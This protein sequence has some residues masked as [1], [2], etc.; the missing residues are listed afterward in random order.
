MTY[1]IQE[2]DLLAY[3]DGESDIN[4][5]EILQESPELQAELTALQQLDTCLHQNLNNASLFDTQDMIDVITGQATEEQCLMIAVQ[6]RSNPALMEE[7]E[8]LR[9]EYIQL[10]DCDEL[11]CTPQEQT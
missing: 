8:R 11:E 4:V 5:Q 7:M 6:L 1:K 9:V 2:G 10:I 3:I